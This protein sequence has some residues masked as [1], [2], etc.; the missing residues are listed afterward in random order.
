MNIMIDV[1]TETKT[2]ILLDKSHKIT[3]FSTNDMPDMPYDSTNNKSLI[4]QW[5]YSI[6]VDHDIDQAIVTDVDVAKWMNKY[7]IQTFSLV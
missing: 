7:G 5:L 4:A 6:A 3:K 1:S 2:A